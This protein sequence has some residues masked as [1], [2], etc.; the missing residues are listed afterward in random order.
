MLTLPANYRQDW[1]SKR[2]SLFCQSVSNQEDKLNNIGC[3]S[4][5]RC[6]RSNRRTRSWWWRWL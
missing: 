3:S 2:S 6:W 1:T 4:L 5:K